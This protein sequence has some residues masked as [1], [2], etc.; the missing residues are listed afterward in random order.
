VRSGVRQSVGGWAEEGG[1]E[2][3]RLTQ[4]GGEEGR[5]RGLLPSG[6]DD[7]AVEALCTDNS[8]HGALLRMVRVRATWEGLV[9]FSDTHAISHI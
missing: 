1:E 9:L 2:R 7:A 5:R 4:E 6:V 3:R 8:A